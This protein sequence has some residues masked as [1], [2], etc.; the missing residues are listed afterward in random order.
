MPARQVRKGLRSCGHRCGRTRFALYRCGRQLLYDGVGRQCLRR[1]DQRRLGRRD[2]LRRGHQCRIFAHQAALAPIHLDQEADGRHVHRGAAGHPDHGPALVVGG[3]LELQVAH[4]PGWRLQADPGE[5]LGRSQ[6]GAGVFQLARRVGDDRN[7]GQQRLARCREHPDLAKT[8]R[9]RAAAQQQQR[10]RQQPVPWTPCAP[11]PW[12]HAA[13]YSGSA[14]ALAH[15]RVR[16]DAP[17]VA[18]ATIRH[19]LHPCPEPRPAN[20]PERRMPQAPA[21]M[22][23]LRRPPVRPPAPR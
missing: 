21:A 5:C 7:L 9:H 10:N 8:K 13:H 16:E 12:F 6:A 20:Q 23:S 1:V 11:S 19:K 18:C 15:A 3:N 14:G 2:S 22:L 17:N 4:Q